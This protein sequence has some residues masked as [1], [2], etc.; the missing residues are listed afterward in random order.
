MLYSYHTLDTKKTVT[1]SV[2]IDQKVLAYHRI[3]NLCVNFFCKCFIMKYY[4]FLF[5]RFDSENK[6]QRYFTDAIA[7][8][9]NY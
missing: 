4:A 3:T 5:I 7:L 6:C 2:T 8:V 1:K 9:Y